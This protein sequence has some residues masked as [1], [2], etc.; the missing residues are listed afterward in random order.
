[1]NYK[2]DPELARAMAALAAQAAGAPRPARGDWQGVRAA[3]S[4]GL[5][6][7]ASIAPLSPGVTTTSFS[8]QTRDG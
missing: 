7:M 5:A 1:M 3:A 8:T 6:Y 4:A 2:L